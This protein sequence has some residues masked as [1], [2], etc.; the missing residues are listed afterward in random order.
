LPCAQA[1][2]QNIAWPAATALPRVM[3]I[4]QA[5]H[6]TISDPALCATV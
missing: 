1:V 4:P 2:E 5:E 3:N 6:L